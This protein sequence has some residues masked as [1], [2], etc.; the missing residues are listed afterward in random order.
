MG[1]K[2]VNGSSTPTRTSVSSDNSNEREFDLLTASFKHYIDNVCKPMKVAIVII[3]LLRRVLNF[4]SLRL[5][6]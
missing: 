6:L 1:R 4:F 3:I 2:N 5:R